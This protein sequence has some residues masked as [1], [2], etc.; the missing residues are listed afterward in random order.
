VGLALVP[1]LLSALAFMDSAPA[2]L[3]FLHATKHQQPKYYSTSSSSSL[4]YTSSLILSKESEIS[5]K[6]CNDG[7]S[8]CLVSSVSL[9]SDRDSDGS[10]YSSSSSSPKEAKHRR[11]DQNK[12]SHNPIND[13]LKEQGLP[14]GLRK[15]LLD[16]IQEVS[17]QRIWI[18]DNSGSMKMM[19]GHETFDPTDTATSTSTAGENDSRNK[20]K[21]EKRKNDD[22]SNDDEEEDQKIKVLVPRAGIVVTNDAADGDTS[23][24][25]ELQQTVNFH[26]RLN[27]VLGAPTEFRFLNKP[28][29][30][31]PQKFRVGYENQHIHRQSNNNRDNNSFIQIF[32]GGQQKRKNV[33]RRKRDS[34]RA[35]KII[36]RNRP[37]GQTA[38]DE[39]VLD[40]K[41]DIVK[42]RPQLLADGKRVTLV[43]CTDGWTDSISDSSGRT[44]P[45]EDLEK[46]LETLKG[47][48]VNVVIRLCTD[49]GNVLDF[50]NGLDDRNDDPSV[51][52]LD[53]L[54]DHEAEAVEVYGHNP[55][56]NYALI[57]HQMREL[58]L[59]G[60]NGLLDILDQ[61]A[62]SVDEIRDFCA[63][64]FGT[65]ADLLPDPLCDWENFVIEVDH[66]QQREQQHWNPS[67]DAVTPWI[68]VEQLLAIQ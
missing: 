41:R 47:L 8:D 64:L 33:G 1:A 4:F 17:S 34:W 38:L 68:D 54:D 3:A 23:R 42:M 61:R 25:T 35:V 11:Y 9:G 18:V 44:S 31:G 6:T 49:F 46:V 57:L 29:N 12:H 53:V 13:W 5:P 40:A 58:G 55:W 19:D 39:A 43:I 45:S 37:K 27:S 14:R 50:Y 16:N 21:N 28:S 30:G 15:A 65:T 67:L 26:A 51:S 52:F 48:P 22:G 60:S 59:Q 20:N 62:L 56:L 36:N 24:W 2:S 63:L 7:T 66:L 32:G 10:T